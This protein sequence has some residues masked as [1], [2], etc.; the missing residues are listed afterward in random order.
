MPPDRAGDAPRHIRQ[1]SY[2]VG[3]PLTAAH[4]SVLQ[5]SGKTEKIF[6]FLLTN[7]SKRCIIV[8]VDS[9]TNTIIQKGEERMA[10]EF[11]SATPLYAQ[12]ASRVRADIVCGVY[13]KGDKLPA[14]RELALAASVN[15]NTMQRAFACLEDEGLVITAGTLGRFVTDDD[16]VI[17]E[18]RERIASFLVADFARKELAASRR[19]LCY[20][21]TSSLPCQHLFSIFF[22]FFRIF[23][24]FR[25]ECKNGQ[26]T[27]CERVPIPEFRPAA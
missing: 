7:L 10:W 8:L 15:P 18:A 1:P 9:Y 25:F 13:K 5:P 14:V 11:D 12:L 20:Y 21:I 19:Q 23:Q 24:L 2:A 22:R 6:I 27:V 3:Q 4:V 16:R 26:C 17:A